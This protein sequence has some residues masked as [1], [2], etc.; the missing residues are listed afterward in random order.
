MAPYAFYQFWL[1]T[2]DSDVVRYLKLFTFLSQEEIASLETEH[3]TNAGAR[4]AH[5][6]LARHMTE[7]LHGESDRLTAEAAAQAALQQRRTAATTTTPW[8]A[9]SC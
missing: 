5:R 7:L 3:A 1:N 2:D 8:T 4:G 6:A 9:A